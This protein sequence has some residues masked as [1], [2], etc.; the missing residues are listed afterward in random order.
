MPPTTTVPRIRR[1]AAPDPVATHNG[2]H[3]TMKARAVI[4]IKT[5]NGHTGSVQRGIA[6]ALPPFVVQFGE[7]DNQDRVLGREADEH[8]QPDR[9][10]NIV[11]KMTCVQSQIRTQNGDGR[12]Q[13]DAEGQCPALH[14]A[15]PG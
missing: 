7:L 3:P 9:R 10:E 1:E 5:R 2:R 6:D 12:A 8:H 14:T 15:Q 4:T 13:Q 11:L